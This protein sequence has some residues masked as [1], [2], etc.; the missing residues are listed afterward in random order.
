MAIM[1]LVLLSLE[2]NGNFQEG[3]ILITYLIFQRGGYLLLIPHPTY[4]TDTHY[5]SHIL[6]QV[7][8]ES[9]EGDATKRLDFEILTRL[10]NFKIV[11]VVTYPHCVQYEL[12]G[13]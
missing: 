9:E 6:R 2:I 11:D 5:L 10:N 7:R 8:H 1:A 13:S 3:K 4:P 12:L